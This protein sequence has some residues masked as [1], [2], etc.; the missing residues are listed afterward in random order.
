MITKLI[1]EESARQKA[2]IN[3]IASE[4]YPSEA[5]K[6]ALASDLTSKYAEGYPGARYY[7]GNAVVD[8]IESAVQD[9]ARKVFRTDYHVNVQP[10]SG[11]IANLAVYAAF[12]QPGEVFMGL[13]LSHGGHL[14]HGHP[15][16][17]TGKLYRRITYHLDQK[18]E[19]LDYDELER[20][21]KEH[22]PKLI[23]SGASSYPRIIDF[24]RISQIAR[25]VGAKHLADI[26][27]ISGLVA[28]GLH[29]SPFGG[30]DVVMTTTHKILR[31]PRAA[32]LFCRPELGNS[33]DRAVFP[34]LQGGPHLNNIAAVGVCLEEAMLPG[35]SQY[36]HQVLK[37]TAVLAKELTAAGLKLVSG[38]TD[39][40]LMLV[41]LRPLK[42]TGQEAQ[43]RLED[44]GIIVNKNAI[45][46]D[47]APP[48]NPSGIRLGT[49]A[50]TTAGFRE[51]NMKKLAR[52]IVLILRKRPTLRA[53]A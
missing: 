32:L 47:L 40:H 14:T 12:L 51:E 10:Y 34:G 2:T 11:S 26:S 49:P 25:S 45:P 16:T 52:K 36:C 53:L 7:A 5:V 9:L 29:P 22:Q 46:F 1:K 27:H 30:A 19:R 39:N 31:G 24:N 37:N 33:I 13:E 21:A 43:D 35:Y 8:K 38:G 42:L 41:D 20:L 23:I 50:V 17:L 15:V 48:N 6:A 44:V 28:T 4:N 18:T 3:L